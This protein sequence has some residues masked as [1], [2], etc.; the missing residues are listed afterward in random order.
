MEMLYGYSIWS[1]V[2]RGD[3]GQTY[4]SEN[5]NFDQDSS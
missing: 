4:R 3:G 1:V 5:L 2:E